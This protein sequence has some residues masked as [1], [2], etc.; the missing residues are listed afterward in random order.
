MIYTL[1][2]ILLLEIIFIYFQ[3]RQTKRKILITIF[4]LIITVIVYIALIV[5]FWNSSTDKREEIQLANEYQEQNFKTILF[6]N[7]LNKKVYVIVNFEYTKDEVQKGNLKIVDYYNKTDSI[8]L[9][10]N[11]N[12]NVFLPVYNNSIA[13]FPIN[14]QIIL[15]DSAFNVIKKYDE[16]LF[17]KDSKTEPKIE[18]T[19]EK[20]KADK[21]E[22]V[23]K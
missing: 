10:P 8:L 16:E 1:L 23:I 7:Q 12:T 9:K 15:K 13:R 14:F 19:E 18:K 5:L 4:A 22:L 21:W 11:E 6:N 17:Y 3:K 2:I 20:Y